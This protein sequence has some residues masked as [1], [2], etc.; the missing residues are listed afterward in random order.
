MK[1]F[2]NKVT[3]NQTSFNISY[4][5]MI[6]F[7]YFMD[8]TERGI[9]GWKHAQRQGEGQGD[10]RANSN[11]LPLMCRCYAVIWTTRRAKIIVKAL[12]GVYMDGC[13]QKP[14]MYWEH[15]FPV[16]E[17]FLLLEWYQ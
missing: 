15:F 7:S 11:E 17:V 9:G 3:G 10:F 1:F 2:Q 8:T 4:W 16:P 6:K 5:D 14:G 13:W 12:D